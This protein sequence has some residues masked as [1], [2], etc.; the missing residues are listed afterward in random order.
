MIS[1]FLEKVRNLFGKKIHQFYLFAGI[2]FKASSK[3]YIW[4]NSQLINTKKSPKICYPSEESP[5]YVAHQAMGIEIEL[6][7]RV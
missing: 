4:I 6:K 7:Y 5:P 3:K 2:F 1:K